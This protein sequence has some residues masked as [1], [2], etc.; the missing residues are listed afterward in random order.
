MVSSCLFWKKRLTIAFFIIIFFERENLIRYC[1]RNDEKYMYIH[2][3][4]NGAKSDAKGFVTDV[5]PAI[6]EQKV[7]FLRRKNMNEKNKN[8]NVFKR[9]NVSTYINSYTY[10]HSENGKLGSRLQPFIV[11][12]SKINIVFHFLCA[13][14][15]RKHQKSG[16]G[17]GKEEKRRSQ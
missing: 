12:I 5:A 1:L 9:V 14:S 10:R 11:D 13:I 2:R 3:I 4:I 7:K 8:E 15:E 6:S 16:R 17:E